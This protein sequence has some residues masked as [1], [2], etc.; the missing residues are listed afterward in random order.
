MDS[1]E[2]KGEQKSMCSQWNRKKAVGL[3]WSAEGKE[4]KVSKVCEK[5]S[6]K[7]AWR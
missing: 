5:D 3:L 4:T 6:M 7:G 2:N 1:K